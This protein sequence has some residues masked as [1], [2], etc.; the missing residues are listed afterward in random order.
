MT[1]I[2]GKCTGK[3]GF[4]TPQLAQKVARKH[5]MAAQHYRCVYCGKFHIGASDLC[6]QKKRLK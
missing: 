1:L 2:A 5:K 3:E 6:F 4:E